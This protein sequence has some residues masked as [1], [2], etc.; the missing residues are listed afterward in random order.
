[1]K[2]SLPFFCKARTDV[3]N[4]KATLRGEQ[5]GEH[6]VD[7]N[8]DGGRGGVPATRHRPLA[9]FNSARGERL[10]GWAFRIRTGDSVRELS[11]WNSLTT[12]PEV[13]QAGRRR[14]F[15]CRS[16]NLPQQRMA[17]RKYKLGPGACGGRIDDPPCGKGQQRARFANLARRF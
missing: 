13:G 3:C 10:P 16:R 7:P 15:A 8:D 12:S 17:A 5:R 9:T 6:P 11:I 2:T 4:G 1:M 14:S